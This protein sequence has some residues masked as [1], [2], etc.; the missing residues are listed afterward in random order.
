[1]MLSDY[2]ITTWTQKDKKTAIVP[3]CLSIAIGA[4]ELLDFWAVEMHNTM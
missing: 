4:P 3:K 2:Q 1:M